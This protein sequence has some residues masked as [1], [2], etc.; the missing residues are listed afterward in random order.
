MPGARC[1]A[2]S[3]SR[4]PGP[5]QLESRVWKSFFVRGR[6]MN[7]SEIFVFKPLS[8][9]LGIERSHELRH[10]PG[11]WSGTRAL[12]AQAVRVASTS[13]KN[14]PR[15][16]KSTVSLATTA[17]SSPL[18]WWQRG[19]AVWCDVIVCAAMGMFAIVC[20]GFFA[21]CLDQMPANSAALASLVTSF[22]WLRQSMQILIAAVNVS[23]SFPWL[24]VAAFA[25][26]FAAYRLVVSLV[27]GASPGENLARWLL[28]S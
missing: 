27:S 9:G 12:A 5:A 13:G 17:K 11:L 4:C 21:A 6:I 20:A 24:P 2:E 23:S 15:S 3:A 16:N 7:R 28:D 8:T 1:T 18:M 10:A 26:L 19:I 14:Q 22:A 25:A